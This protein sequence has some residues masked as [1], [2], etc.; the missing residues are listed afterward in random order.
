MMR[1]PIPIPPNEGQSLIF[2]LI[3]ASFNIATN[4]ACLRLG[5]A[6]GFAGTAFRGCFTFAG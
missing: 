4:S 1:S 3:F 2:I 6:V 5:F